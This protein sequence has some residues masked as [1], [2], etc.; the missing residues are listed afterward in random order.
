MA[1]HRVER[2]EDLEFAKL[3]DTKAHDL[4]AQSGL[5]TIVSSVCGRDSRPARTRPEISRSLAQ[6]RLMVR[7]QLLIPRI[8]GPTGT[9][10]RIDIVL[11]YSASLP[12]YRYVIPT[13][14]IGLDLPREELDRRI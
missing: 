3:I 5:G 8:A 14:Q 1:E 2:D 10:F 9:V 7:K 12:H 11:P 13:V 4:H 6:E